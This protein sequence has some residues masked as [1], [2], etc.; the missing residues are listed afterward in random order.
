MPRAHSH[1]KSA[2]GAADEGWMD[3][4]RRVRKRGVVVSFILVGGSG[5]GGEGVDGSGDTKARIER[6]VIGHG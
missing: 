6:G 5:I 4:A 3:R 1:S 2:A